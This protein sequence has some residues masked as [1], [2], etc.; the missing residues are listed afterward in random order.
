MRAALVL[1][2]CLLSACSVQQDQSA[3]LRVH[4]FY[5]TYL[6]SLTSS[7]KAYSPSE[8]REYVSADTLKRLDEIEAIPEQDLIGS[9]YF[10]YAQ[11]YDPSWVSALTVGDAKPFMGG[12]ILPVWIGK[13]YGG[14]LEL[15]VFV[16][17]ESGIW[18]IY[19]VRD[20]TDNYEHPIF[21]AGAIARAKFAAESGL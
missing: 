4:S 11:D 7:D 1:Y 14:K 16:R 20:V 21:N 5:S 15:Q 12:E 10:A 18:K 2:T 19:R 3:P 13:E 6:M 8:L 17:R 9:D